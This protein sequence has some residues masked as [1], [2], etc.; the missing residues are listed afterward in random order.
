MYRAKDLGRGQVATFDQ[1]ARIFAIGRVHTEQLLRHALERDE[2]RVVYQPI[3]DMQTGAIVSAEALLR[4]QHPTDG[5][6]GPDRFMSIAEETGLI[7]PIG[8][9][10]LSQACAQMRAWADRCPGTPPIGITVNL[11][12]RQLAEDHLLET[13]D[14]VVAAHRID[15][16]WLSLTLEVTESLLIRDPETAN[17]R[18]A[19]LKSRGVHL[20]MD[21]FGTG[22]SSLAYLRRFP[23]DILKIDRTF[24]EGVGTPR[25][26][27]IVKAIIAMA[28]GLDITVVA[29]GVE[30]D[31]QLAVLR[32]LGCDQAQ[33]FRI[34][35][36]QSAPRLASSLT[37]PLLGAVG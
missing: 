8:E 11:S 25:D 10:V 32:E 19:E 37:G 26:H 36:P 28:H 5:L 14:A 24:V 18:L 2:L 1:T 16:V 20:A 33:G 35:R 31:E 17:R 23:F 29:E 4:W 12:P 34:G 30:T 9:W 7:V 21:D 15:P 27:A 3:I 6:I 13:I 22:Y